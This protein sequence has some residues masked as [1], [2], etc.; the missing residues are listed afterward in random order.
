MLFCKLFHAVLQFTYEIYSFVDPS[1]LPLL[2]QSL[3]LIKNSYILQLR[4]LSQE[5]FAMEQSVYTIV[6]FLHSKYTLKN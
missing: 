5:M 4:K 1:F 6:Y 2:S 3:Y